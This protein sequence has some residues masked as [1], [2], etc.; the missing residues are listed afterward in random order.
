MWTTSGNF[1]HQAKTPR[2]DVPQSITTF[3]KVANT[4]QW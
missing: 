1:L 3:A 2:N 4:D